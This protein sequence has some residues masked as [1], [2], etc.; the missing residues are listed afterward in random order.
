MPFYVRKM[1]KSD[2]PQV[3]Q[4]AKTSWNHTYEGIIPS[5]IQERF[6]EFAY[7]DAML[8]KRLARSMMFVSEVGEKIVGFAGFS[9]VQENGHAELTAIYIDPAHQSNGLGTA[10]LNEGLK[11]LNDAQN[12]FVN[13]EKENDSGIAFYKAK[14]FTTVT[15]FAEKF[16]GHILKTVRM[17]LKL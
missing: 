5:E 1:Q 16:D 8:N 3:R 4:V 12:I 11:H 13:V 6:L 2:I 9:P 7:S 17:V 15:E 10:L 14:G